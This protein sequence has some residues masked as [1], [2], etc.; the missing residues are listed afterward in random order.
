[1]TPLGGIYLEIPKKGLDL[2][3]PPL[4]GIR[5]FTHLD[6]MVGRPNFWPQSPAQCAEVIHDPGTIG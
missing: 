1:M 3:H 2:G 4:I 6:W 5:L